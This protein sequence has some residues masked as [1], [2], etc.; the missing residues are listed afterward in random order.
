MKGWGDEAVTPSD[1]LLRDRL[2]A[3]PQTA[4]DDARPPGES[5]LEVELKLS[6][7]ARALESLWASTVAP[8]TKS[9][10][11][12]LVSTYFDTSDHRL[13]RRG[14]TVRI[15]RDG[16]NCVQTVKAGKGQPGS[17]TQRREWSTPIDAPV[18][19]LRRLNDSELLERIGLIIAGDLQPV[20]T[21]EVTR[22]TKRYR[23]DQGNGVTARIEAALDRGEIRCNGLREAICE[24]ELE[25]LDGSPVAL[26]KE[27]ARL[28]EN[29]P[30]EYQ[31]LSK[32][33][34]GFALA[35]GERPTGWKAG[36]LDLS[37][38]ESV[39][40]GLEHILASCF[41]HWLA[42]H[43][44][45]LDGGDPEGVHQ[46][47]IALRRLHSALSVFRDAL[48][49]DDRQWLQREAKTLIAGLG[50][51]RDWDVFIEDLLRPVMSARPDD[52]GLKTLRDAV[53]ER[54]RQ[55]YDQA[56]ARLRS[57]EYFGFVL[58]FGAW[59]DGRGWRRPASRGAFERRLIDLAE[60]VLSKRHKQVIKR[61]RGFETL[62]DEALHRLRISVKKL[63][64][65]T[66]F[67][68]ALYS[69]SGTGAYLKR[70]RR[71]QDDF[72]YLNDLAVAEARLA[73][74][75]GRLDQGDPAGLDGP[76]GVLI[77]WH[78]FAL[79]RIRPRIAE[80]WRAFTR[81]RPF[82]QPTT[83]KV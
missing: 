64:Y 66:E 37:A 24:L 27:A 68:A 9:T 21:T 81:T 2:G 60:E 76:S 59:L 82:W 45:V 4:Q 1:T 28:L 79:A 8:R 33:E 43:A 53:N 40:E 44:A 49:A 38:D 72:G 48:P 25:L 61:G 78:S 31:P 17:V 13:R 26:Q 39:E 15:R 19:D 80:D 35:F 77:G 11:R 7:T 36:P 50:G 70:L 63:R 62:S 75:R 5:H 51:A 57:P 83:A 54:R 67:F 47:R 65:A 12:R 32:A 3:D 42:N 6:G 34:R 18:P 23:V 71:L 10:T 74:L 16:T 22:Q 14:L 69:E 52:D 56:R 73:D 58:D 29:A 30:L 55:A 20:F 46:M 41:D